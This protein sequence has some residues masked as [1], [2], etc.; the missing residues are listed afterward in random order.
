MT[1]VN[2][3]RALI[4]TENSNLNARMGWLLSTQ[5]L[6][7]AAMAFAWNTGGVLIFVISAMGIC[8]SLSYG[9]Y[10]RFSIKAFENIVSN[11]PEDLKSNGNWPRGKTKKIKL[12]NVLGYYHGTFCR[13]AL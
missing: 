9:Y 8:T 4:D 11:V 6:L 12:P 13:F 2:H 5:S 1:D 7:F 3:Y 10:L